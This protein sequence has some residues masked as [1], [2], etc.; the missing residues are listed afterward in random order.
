MEHKKTMKVQIEEI[1]ATGYQLDFGTVF[2]SAFENYKK[3]ALY[4]GLMLLVFSILISIIM[5]AGL[6]SYLGIENI[7]E[8]G[9]KMKQMSTLKVMPLEIAVP[10]NA[11]LILISA[12]ISPFTAGFLKMA[13]C[14]EQGEEFHVSTMFSYYKFPYFSTIFISVFLIGII[15]SGLTMLLENV[16]LSF[17]GTLTTLLISFITFLTIPLIVFGNLNAT[18][19]IKN[20]II[21]VSKQPLILIGL[22]IVAGIGAALGIFGLCVGVFFTWPFMY[23]M[24]YIIYK[25]IIGFEDTSEIDEISGIED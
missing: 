12:I 5:L 17:V 22:S 7:E 14:G 8:F 20:S 23:S 19:A 1:S 9:N 6:I 18:D 15:S 4:A 24:N 11:G 10:L 2:E 3:I 21:L 16:G 25:S 13:D